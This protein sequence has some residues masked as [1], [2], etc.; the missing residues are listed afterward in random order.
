LIFKLLKT[1]KYE[2]DTKSSSY[3]PVGSDSPKF[4]KEIK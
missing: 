3:Y 1:K 2:S 4:K